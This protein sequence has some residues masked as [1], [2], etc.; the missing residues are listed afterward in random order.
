VKSV[1]FFKVLGKGLAIIRIPLQILGIEKI[2]G[3]CD[4]TIKI[5]LQI[6]GNVKIQG[7]SCVTQYVSWQHFK[8]WQEWANAT[9]G[10]WYYMC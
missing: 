2:L 6:S 5:P 9:G 3:I 8:T 7:T 1:E 4:V 10:K